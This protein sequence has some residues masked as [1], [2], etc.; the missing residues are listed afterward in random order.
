ME[1]KELKYIKIEADLKEMIFSGKIRPGEKIPSEN[2]LAAEYQVSRQTVRKALNELIH[3]GYIYPEHG[4]GTFCSDMIRH[5]RN[6]KNIGVIMTYMSDYIFPHV[7]KGINSVLE[8]D[9]YSIILKTTN[10]SRTVE[11][12][13]LEELLK[14]DIDG[15][16]IEPS[17]SHIYCKHASLYKK[18]DEYKIP[19]VFIQGCYSQ[20]RDTCPHVL[21]DDEDGGYKIT[22]Y[23]IDRGHK[24]IAGVFKSDDSQGQN[25][26]KGYVRAL[27]EAGLNYDPDSVIWYYTEDR[28]IHSYTSVKKMIETHKK[29]DAIVCYN[30]Q[31]A[32]YVIKAIADCGLK[33]PDD[34]SVTGYD[35]FRLANSFGLQLTTIRHPQ[36]KLGELAADMLI[37]MLKNGNGERNI[38]IHPEIVEGNSVR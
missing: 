13:C 4:R 1:G 16:I 2:T 30:D 24:K 29:P 5:K 6:S 12:R 11:V 7:L 31:I 10:N 8:K 38:V 15:F 35:D 22:R 32:L 23:L 18:L 14:K 34:I 36:E 33:V 20:M 27:N 26:H 17:K 19:Y 3:E 21:M 25:R 28:K 9:D 37:D